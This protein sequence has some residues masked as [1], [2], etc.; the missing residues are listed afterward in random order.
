MNVREKERRQSPRKTVREWAKIIID[1][2]RAVRN[3]TISDISANG[4]LLVTG[5]TDTPETF[6]LY[7]KADQSLREA[8]VARRTGQSVG[9]RLASPLDPTSELAQTLMAAL[10]RSA[11]L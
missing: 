4:A 7:R 1:G 10:R 3:C 9:V 8:V 2:G 5:T 11:K 6:F